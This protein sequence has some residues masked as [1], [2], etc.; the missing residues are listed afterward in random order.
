MT[1]DHL[2]ALGW[3]QAKIQQILDGP[4]PEDNPPDSAKAEDPIPQTEAYLRSLGWTQS[5]IAR[6][7]VGPEKSHLTAESLFRQHAANSSTDQQ[8]LVQ[9]LTQAGA[10]A[11]KPDP[12]LLEGLDPGHLHPEAPSDLESLIAQFAQLPDVQKQRFLLLLDSQK[13]KKSSGTGSEESRRPPKS[14][15][16]SSGGKTS[17]TAGAE[18]DV[19]PVVKSSLDLLSTALK[20]LLGTTGTGKRTQADKSNAKRPSDS[21]RSD[22]DEETD[23]E[24]DKDSSDDGDAPDTADPADWDDPPEPEEDNP[25]PTMPDEGIG[26]GDEREP[27]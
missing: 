18:G 22:E 11:V 24:P 15:A 14:S 23:T 12:Q 17:K 26:F 20:G 2:R 3:S 19:L 9:A 5:D 27:D 4:E 21:D 25:L 16:D 7:L 1:A 6:L 10:K 13:P 8:R